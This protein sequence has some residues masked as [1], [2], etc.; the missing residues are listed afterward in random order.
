MKLS[1]IRSEAAIICGRL[2]EEKRHAFQQGLTDLCRARWKEIR[3]NE[4]ADS[5]ARAIW[6]IDPPLSDL[7]LDLI[8]SGDAR[9]GEAL[10][11]L[12]PAQGLALLILAEIEEGNEEGARIAHESMM[13]FDS[14]AAGMHHAAKIASLLRGNIPF[15]I[16]HPHSSRPALWKALG[17]IAQS[18]KRF[19]VSSA[20]VAMGLLSGKPGDRQGELDVLGERLESMGIRF[21]GVE[22]DH[23]RY[24]VHGREKSPLSRRQAALMLEEIRAIRIS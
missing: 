21:L 2:P 8:A 22:D 6:M 12:S 17:I 10:H 13:L 3:G 7:F 15:R 16:H 4:P 14:G 18:T 9:L 23:I 20:V 1:E 19:D 24:S 11:G 5:L